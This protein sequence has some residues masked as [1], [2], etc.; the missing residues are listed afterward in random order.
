MKKIIIKS[1]LITLAV[2]VGCALAVFAI[3]SFG[4]P[5]TLCGWCEQLGNYGF[6]ARYA[7]L[8]YS[9]T[10]DVSALGRCVDDSILAEDDGFIIDYGSQLIEREDFSG[11]CAER[12]EEVNGNI[13]SDENFAGITFSYRQYVYGALSTAYYGAGDFN[14]A[15]GTAVVSL[16][17]GVDRTSFSAEEYSGE[18]VGFPVNNALGLLSLRII[19]AEDG[20]AADSV[21]RVFACVT[22]DGEA[23]EQYFNTLSGALSAL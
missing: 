1:A 21:L 6:A 20:V 4:F 17:Y 18:I 15:L 2:V 16:D 19:E 14:L 8:Y 10:D 7:S 22:P 13:S 23:E 5:N 11:Y 12:D 9:Y 3:L